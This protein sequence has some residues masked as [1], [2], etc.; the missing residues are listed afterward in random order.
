VAREGKNSYSTVDAQG[1]TRGPLMRGAGEM[2]RGG[3]LAADSGARKFFHF[4]SCRGWERPKNPPGAGIANVPVKRGKPQIPA[5]VGKNLRAGTPIERVRW[6]RA[7]FGAGFPRTWDWTGR[8]RARFA[9]RG[10]PA[11]FSFRRAD[12]QGG[13]LIV[14]H[15]GGGKN[16]RGE[17]FREALER[18][19]KK[20]K[21]SQSDRW[22]RYMALPGLRGILAA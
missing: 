10:K 19:I 15:G 20:G 2:L 3:V 1:F 11:S 13:E 16:L 4:V 5:P 7:V 6:G 21:N 12:I 18:G 8:F 22:P 17:A 9:G 14:G